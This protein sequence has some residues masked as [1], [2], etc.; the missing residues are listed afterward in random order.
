[1]ATSTSV[2]KVLYIEDDSGL[3]ELYMTR[4]GLDGYEI[5]HCAD[6]ESALEQ[7]RLFKPDLIVLDLMMPNINGFDA[8]QQFR[9]MPE[10]A[11]AKIIVMSA[12]NQ[13]E[14]MQKA[15]SL[16]A[17]DYLVKSQIQMDEVADVVKR[18]LAG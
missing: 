11:Q 12:L 13:P 3:A 6:G 5:V 15:K 4:L 7:G 18:V 16:G 14:D 8:L 9:S 1:M 2:P 17:D 10:T